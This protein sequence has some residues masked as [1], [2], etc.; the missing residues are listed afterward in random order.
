MT[1]FHI[2]HP[3][4]NRT[5]SKSINLDKQ[6]CYKMGE[7]NIFITTGLILQIKMG[8][9]FYDGVMFQFIFNKKNNKC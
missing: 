4:E 3:E 1:F 7:Y 2:E 9:F 8:P 5:N 6:L